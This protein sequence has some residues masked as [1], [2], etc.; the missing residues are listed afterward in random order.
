MVKINLFYADWCGH[1]KSFKPEWE[2]LKNIGKNNI[3][4]FEYEDS[5]DTEAIN[6]NKI[7]SYPTIRIEVDNNTFDYNGMRDADSILE[8]INHY[9]N[10]AG[11]YLVNKKRYN[12][13]YN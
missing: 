1:C 7:E 8:S 5:K 4:F 9:T 11:G 6:S 3:E 2:K 12:I 10:Q 13:T